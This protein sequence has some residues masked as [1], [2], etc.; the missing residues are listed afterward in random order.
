MTLKKSTI[1]VTVVLILLMT[2]LAVM[3]ENPAWKET[4]INGLK[5]N[6]R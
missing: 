5:M 4:L 2:V 6:L 1:A 3:A